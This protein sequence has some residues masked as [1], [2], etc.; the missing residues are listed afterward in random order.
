MAENGTKFEKMAGRIIRIR[1][2]SGEIVKFEGM[3]IKLVKFEKLTAIIIE[4]KINN[5]LKKLE[6]ILKNG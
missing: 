3:A 5:H 2:M 6:E 1:K 4:K